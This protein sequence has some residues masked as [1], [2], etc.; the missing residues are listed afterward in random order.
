[1]SKGAQHAKPTKS[2]HT[3]K[4]HIY[5][6]SPQTWRHS[7]LKSSPWTSSLNCHRQKDTTRYSRSPTMIAQKLHCSSHATKQL[8]AKEWRSY[9]YST[10]I[11]TMEYPKDSSRIGDHSSYRSSCETSVKSWESNRISHQHITPRQ[12]DSRSEAINGS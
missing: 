4:S 12:T 1:M 6:P 2:T 5:S 8:R 7:H 10:P 11:P 3:T 9:T